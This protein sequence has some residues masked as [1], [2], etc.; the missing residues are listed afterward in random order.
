MANSR[1]ISLET[2]YFVEKN[3]VGLTEL[4]RGNRLSELLEAYTKSS[5]EIV[6]VQSAKHSGKAA[7]I[8]LEHLNELVA[9]KEMY[10]LFMKDRVIEKSGNSTI[11]INFSDPERAKL[12]VILQK[13]KSENLQPNKVREEKETLSLQQDIGDSVL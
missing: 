13:I 8:N 12:A 5:K 10:E 1:D 4:K 9:M 11:T 2:L 7:I 3:L 6:V